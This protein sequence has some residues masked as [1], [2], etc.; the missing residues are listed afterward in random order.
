MPALNVCQHAQP[1]LDSVT[2]YRAIAQNYGVL[3]S[4]Q[5]LFSNCIQLRVTLISHFNPCISH[6]ALLNTQIFK[7]SFSSNKKFTLRE[8]PA[9]NNRSSKER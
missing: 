5:L 8:Y 3:Y 6:G 7:M 4:L 2:T 9:C 1:Q